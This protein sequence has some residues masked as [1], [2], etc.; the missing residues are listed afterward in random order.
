MR[1]VVAKLDKSDKQYLRHLI[2]PALI[3]L[4]ALAVLADAVVRGDTRD[5]KHTCYGEKQ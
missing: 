3:L 2:V 4:S 1:R 5:C